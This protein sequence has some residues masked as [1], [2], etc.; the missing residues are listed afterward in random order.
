MK[1]GSGFDNTVITSGKVISNRSA[2]QG[3]SNTI[4]NGKTEAGVMGEHVEPEIEFYLTY[5]ND[6]IKNSKEIGTIQVIV[7][8]YDKDGAKQ[9]T[10][11]MN[12]EIVTKATALSPQTVDLYATQA[13][14][15]T[16][17]L[18][19]PSG[20]DR[21]LTLTGVKAESNLV[22]AD[23]EPKDNEFSI[24]MKPEQGQGWKATGLMNA[25]YDLAKYSAPSSIQIGSTDGRYDA[26]ILFTLKNMQGFAAKTDTDKVILTLKDAASGSNFDV[27]LEV[28]WKASAVSN[29]NVGSGRQYNEVTAASAINNKSAITAEFTLRQITPTADLWI[30]LQQSNGEKVKLPKGTKVTLIQSSNFYSYE[31]DG[32]EK[33]KKIPLI[34]FKQMWG[35]TNLTGNLGTEPLTIIVDFELSEA[36]ISSDYSL[37]LRTDKAADPKG[38]DFTVKPGEISA[39]LS[40]GDGLS[41]GEHS[42]TLNFST[43]GDTRLTGGAI[44]VLSPG[45]GTFPKGTVFVY[46]DKKYYPNEGK[47]YLPLNTDISHVIKMDTTKSVG[48]TLGTQSLKAEFFSTGLS[49]GKT[50]QPLASTS[51]DYQVKANPSYEIKVAAVNDN[52]IAEK[53]ATLDFSIDYSVANIGEE[54]TKIKVGVEQ[55]M[56]DQSYEMSKAWEV[57]GN[58]GIGDGTENRIITVTIPSDLAPGTYRLLFTLGDQEVPYNIIVFSDN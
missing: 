43:G 25:S 49:T 42:Y 24:V 3:D 29:I 53:G 44:A 4:I 28:H 34:E 55:K 13:G 54:T 33:D 16:G 10:T 56:P 46:R 8:R 1:V 45:S 7:D 40:G 38:A 21:E 2:V 11:T 47:V 20:N 48:L 19:I 18:L 17:K 50:E 35:K 26:P 39:T 22:A 37:R 27:T 41:R 32:A 58:E 30:E 23:Q 5:D 15:Y 51:A 52:R 12:V 9:E 6:G 31:V 14:S 36:L 57:T